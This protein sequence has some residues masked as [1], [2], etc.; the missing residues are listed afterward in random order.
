MNAEVFYTRYQRPSASSYSY[1]E[2]RKEDS[3]CLPG[4]IPHFFLP[5]LGV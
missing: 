5:Y 2:A 3:L 1:L 4:A